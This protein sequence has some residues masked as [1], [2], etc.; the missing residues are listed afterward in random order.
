MTIDK[1][2]GYA[3]LITMP[4]AFLEKTTLLRE[5]YRGYNGETLTPVFDDLY[6]YFFVGFLIIRFINLL[7]ESRIIKKTRDK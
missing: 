6:W 7:I 3:F 2:L 1:L 4:L 5:Y